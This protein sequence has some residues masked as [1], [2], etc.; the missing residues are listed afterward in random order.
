MMSP[1]THG[2]G[3]TNVIIKVGFCTC[4]LL[5]AALAAVG[6]SR[7]Q[8]LKKCVSS[9]PDTSIAGCTALI[10]AGRESTASLVGAY[11]RR[12][13][14]YMRKGDY[15][16]AIHDYDDATRLNP[17]D[18]AAYNDRGSAYLYKGDYDRAIQNY[19]DAIHL[20]P[21]DAPAY[22][23]RGGAYFL[24]G[25][26]DSA[27]QDF[28]EAIRLNP[29]EASIAYCSRGVA[30]TDMGDYDRAIQDYD[31]AIRLSPKYAYAYYNRGNAYID[32]GDYGRAIKDL[33]EAIR[34][35]PNFA[36][37]YY[38]RGDAYLFQ[39]N[40]T[41][42]MA[43]FEHVISAEPS[44][45]TAVYAALMLHVAMKRQGRDDA[46]QLPP[47]AEAA[48][49]SKWP[50]PMLKLDLGQMAADEVMAAAANAG[51]N[52]QKRQVCEANYFTGED[53]LLH[54]Q[55]TTALARF[56]AARD[57]CPKGNIG[58]AEA[59]AELRRLSAPDAPAK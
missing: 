59:L 17:N 10:Q 58:Y 46:Q 8:N 54:N 5:G 38:N 39:S 36:D 26:R 37:A 9:D 31:D 25:D 43:D 34:L 41:A 13:S 32:M 56:K 44:S 12:A 29:N 7:R 22:T 30:Y 21:N 33:N 18:A 47:V 35:S 23:G 6:Q 51:A 24:K 40:L 48:D 4:L 2:Q 57:G 3:A 19:D 11:S 52:M 14:A 16:R 53:A 1:R 49:L 45:S 27:I 55:P 20:H 28:N 42:A 50:G 15:D